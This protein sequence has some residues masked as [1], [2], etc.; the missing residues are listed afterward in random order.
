MISA[1]ESVPANLAAF[2]ASLDQAQDII[3]HLATL[4]LPA[5]RQFVGVAEI[6]HRVC[7]LAFGPQPAGHSINFRSI[8]GG[9]VDFPL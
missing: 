1:G 7:D 2:A 8:S 5:N 6:A 4:V 9:T 3:R